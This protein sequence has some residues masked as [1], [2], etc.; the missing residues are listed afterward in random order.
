MPNETM[1]KMQ[2]KGINQLVGHSR[3]GISRACKRD[4]I[5]Q[6]GSALFGIMKESGGRKETKREN[7]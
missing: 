4:Q 5:G 6:S 2:A 1:I 7:D 3:H